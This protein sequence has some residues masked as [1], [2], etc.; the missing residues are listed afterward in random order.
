MSNI[1]EG[2]VGGQVILQKPQ[3]QLPK[4][5]PAS[6]RPDQAELFPGGSGWMRFDATTQPSPF[7]FSAPDWMFP[8]V[9]CPMPPNVQAKPPSDDEKKEFLIKR[10]FHVEEWLAA[11]GCKRTIQEGYLGLSFDAKARSVSRIGNPCPVRLSKKQAGLFSVL[12]HVGPSGIPPEMQPNAYPGTD[13]AR[14]TAVTALRNKLEALGVTI[15][16][17]SWALVDGPKREMKKRKKSK[18]L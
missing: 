13:E 18:R 12:L 9:T 14:R 6:S 17:R 8:Q 7:D 5:D 3:P 1:Q 4:N 16:W 11:M 2:K 15:N 10:V